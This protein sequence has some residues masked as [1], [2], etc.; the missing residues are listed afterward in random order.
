V[1]LGWFVNIGKRTGRCIVLKRVSRTVIAI[2]TFANIASA[3]SARFSGVWNSEANPNLVWNVDQSDTAVKVSVTVAGKQVQTTEWLF[4][5]P[6]VAELISG[7]SAQTAARV[8]GEFLSFTGPVVL[9]GPP[10]PAT[11]QTTPMPGTV[12]STWRLSRNGD[13]LTVDTRIESA[14]SGTTFSRQ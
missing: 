4:D 8:D 1:A 3:Q 7:L 14:S 6:P 12:Q 2:L 11:V 13:E 10:I 5:G 9:K